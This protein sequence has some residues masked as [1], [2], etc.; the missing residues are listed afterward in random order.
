MSHSLHNHGKARRGAILV[1]TAVLMIMI[2]A[3]LAFAVDL[4]YVALTRT[5][6]QNA[7]D[8]GALA[9]A[10]TMVGGFDAAAEEAR[11]YVALHK[12]N[13]TAIDES[14]TQIRF[15]NW[16]TQSR[17]FDAGGDEPNA[18]E[19]TL[20]SSSRPFFFA[21]VLGQDGFDCEA[22]AIASFSP[23]DIMLVLDFSGSMCYD[24]QLRSIDTLGRAAVEANLLQIYT[25]LGSPAFGSM[26]WAP[27]Y[28]SS[29]NITTVKNWL[30]LKNVPYP[31]PS[32]SWDNYISYIMNDSAIYRAGYRKKYGYLTWVNYLLA[33]QPQFAETPSLWMTSEQPVTAVKD[34]VDLLVAYLQENCENDRL[35]LSLY[36]SS[37]GTAILE[38][39]MTH[40]FSE[41][42]YK[43]RRRQAGHYNVYTNIYDGMKTARLEFQNN[44]RPTA[45]RLMVLMTD[46]QANLPGSQ[47]KQLALSE[48]R[49]AAGA[50]I[51][52]VTISLGAGADTQLMQQIADI[53]KGVYFEIPGGQTVNQYEE[54][55]KD[56]FR[57]VASDR[58]LALVQ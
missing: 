16:D 52:I 21:R 17:R 48:A 15:G 54:Q 55:L 56:V 45:G 41:V 5:E 28:N 43:T 34:A 44:G 40:E 25:E 46:G 10:G 26:K 22:K 1:L 50:R 37:N 53:T 36:T 24:S 12:T 20:R 42:A 51:P 49:A 35:G 2:F 23:R 4:G 39:P 6:L 8:A 57:R 38:S 9:G 7:A 27:Q 58:K 31:Y 13:G 3:M 30:G 32:G 19:I 29:S 33:E 18:M 47:A 14:Q 11:K